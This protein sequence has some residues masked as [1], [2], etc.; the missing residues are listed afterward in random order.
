MKAGRLK[1]YV[2][3]ALTAVCTLAT[4]LLFVTMPQYSAQGVK[5][6]LV[7]CVQTVIPA[8]FPF[9][10]LSSFFVKTGLCSVLGK[11]LSPV[12]KFLFALPGEAGGVILMGLCGG[13]PVGASM[14]SALLENG[15]ISKHEAGRMMLFCV[16]AGPAFV[17][18]A[19][20]A[21]MLGSIR[22]GVLLFCSLTAASLIVGFLSRFVPDKDCEENNCTLCRIQSQPLRTA[23][24]LAVTD[25]TTAIISVCAWVILFS[26]MLE[27]IPLL[28]LSRETD[29]V[30]NCILEVTRGCAS[31]VELQ[32]IPIVAA[33]LG[34]S[35]FSVHCQVMRYVRSVEVPF[36]HFF[37]ARIL[38]G[39][40]A[41]ILCA[42]LLEIFPCT[43][44][45]FAQGTQTVPV[46]FSFSAPAAAAMLF[47]GALLI[48]ELDTKRKKC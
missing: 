33:A 28:G 9:C 23:L 46:A 42:G 34:W 20:G 7:I 30:L 22:A 21:G 1:V 19:V 6:G 25:G 15:N 41:A 32:N 45:T 3:F 31:A 12:T 29:I 11:V 17:I 5:N 37:C 16:N 4:A 26:C 10:V 18:G 8:L 13:F 44:E 24:P 2:R 40:I 47:M 48:L 35:G 36:A 27:Y 14:T 39:A 43:V 38:N